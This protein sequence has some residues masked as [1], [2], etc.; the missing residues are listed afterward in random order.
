[1]KTINIRY[2]VD[3]GIEAFLDPGQDIGP[4]EGEGRELQDPDVPH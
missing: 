2:G 1:M 3:S 4:V